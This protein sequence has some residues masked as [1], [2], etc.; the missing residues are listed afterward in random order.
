MIAISQSGES[1]D[2][3][4]VAAEA[5]RQGAA[6]LAITNELDSPL[7]QSAEFAIACHAG[8]EI[9]VAA[10][11]TYTAQLVALALLAAHWSGEGQKK[12]QIQRL[13]KAG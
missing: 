13:P 1:P 9:S 6:T 3:V 12:R 5:R 7:A 2:I 8:I 11:K 10:T 4:A